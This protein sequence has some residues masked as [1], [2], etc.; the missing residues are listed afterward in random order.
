MTDITK[1]TEAARSLRQ[2]IRRGSQAA[3]KGEVMDLL[4]LQIEV[5]TLCKEIEAL[6]KDDTKSLQGE[7]ISLVEELSHLSGKLTHGLDVIKTEL[8]SLAERQK[9]VS[10][11]GKAP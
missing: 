5:N 3:E 9:A 11:Y 8:Q 2:K 4:P 7:V 10:A 1:I 6:P